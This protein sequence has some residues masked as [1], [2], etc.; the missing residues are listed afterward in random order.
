MVSNIIILILL[1]TSFNYADARN[2]NNC[3]CSLSL[4]EII[5][6]VERNYPGYQAK[7]NVANKN[8]YKNFKAKTIKLAATSTDR[9]NCFYII[10]SYIRFF[11]DNHIIFSDRNTAPKQALFTK[12]AFKNASDKLT[13]VWR[14]NNDSLLVRVVR[15]SKNKDLF[16]YKAYILN[17][18]GAIG[19]VHFELIGSEHEFRVRKY[20][21]SL[22]TDLL[23]GRRLRNLLIEPGGIWQKIGDQQADLTI[24]A[25]S[26]QDNSKF[27][28]KSI[29]DN[30]HYLGIPSFT[31]DVTKFDSIIVK[32][33]IPQMAV[34]KIQHLIID[35]RNNV[36]GN[37]SFLSLMRLAYEK[38][39][40]IPGD[41][42]LST[43]KLIKNY[44]TSPSPY[45]K[46][47][48]PKLKANI[49][50]FV[51]RDSLKIALKESQQYP[52]TISIIVNEN[53]ASSSEYFLILA[54]HSAKV[55]LYGRHT[56]GTLDYSELLKPENLSCPDY[57]F[58]RPTT[59]SYWTDTSPID[60]TGIQ[61]DVD[62][63]SYPENEW[64]DIIV[65]RHLD[66][67]IRE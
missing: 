6:D 66:N 15:E 60:N 39:F 27:I 29:G 40:S 28:F 12:K 30:I 25:S 48:I 31:M 23:R 17:P 14:R 43:P 55:K 36:G 16:T 9:E 22:T 20:D 19:N 18:T 42:L 3:N 54:K 11:K 38:P 65:D 62:L 5:S 2:G 53:S 41:F 44:E 33:I 64:I 52:E 7:V 4:E 67:R 37:S 8:E 46:A 47:M 13:G 35:L 1:I 10:E 49:G 59:K 34:G 24:K 57:S 26:Y 51:Q 45:R 58:M 56:A 61:P 50:K 32:Q 63:S 21:S